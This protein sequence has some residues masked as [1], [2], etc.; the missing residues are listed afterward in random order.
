MKVPSESDKR[1]QL[2]TLLQLV[3]QR[4]HFIVLMAKITSDLI[5]NGK[6]NGLFRQPSA[7]AVGTTPDSGT[8]WRGWATSLRRVH[9]PNVNTAS[10][11][12]EGLRWTLT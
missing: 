4:N 9:L 7:Q 2:S 11:V 3:F 12:V 10:G 1:F 8:G 6:P 5:W